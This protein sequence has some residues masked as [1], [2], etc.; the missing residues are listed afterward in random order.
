MTFAALI[1][2]KYFAQ[3]FCKEQVLSLVY[4]ATGVSRSSIRAA[5][6]GTQVSGQTAKDLC[7]WAL[8]AHQ[9]ELDFQALVCAPTKAEKFRQS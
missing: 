6:N 7:G 9:V 2:A 1:Q 8:L 4:V 3:G 5:L